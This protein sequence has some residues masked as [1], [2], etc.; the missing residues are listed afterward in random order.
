MVTFAPCLANSSTMALPIP[1]LPPVTMA[2][3]FFKSMLNSSVFDDYSPHST[4]SSYGWHF[5]ETLAFRVV[6]PVDASFIAAIQNLNRPGL[7]KIVPGPIDEGFDSFPD[8]RHQ[9]GV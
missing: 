8:P 7:A 3:L 9:Q 2:T 5:A 1:L 6:T 4:D